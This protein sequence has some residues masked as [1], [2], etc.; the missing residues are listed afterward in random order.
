MDNETK[1]ILSEQQLLA[2]VTNHQG[3]KLVRKIFDNQILVL[4]SI[5]NLD[6]DN[7]TPEKMF[8]DMQANKKASDIVYDILREIESAS[9]VV[10]DN[11]PKRA[12][13]IVDLE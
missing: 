5:A 10:E 8:R 6:L 11:K 3:W 2:E 12:S 9:S 13:Y 1:N 4:Q 7:S